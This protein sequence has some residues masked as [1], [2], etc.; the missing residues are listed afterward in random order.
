MPSI[1]T[2]IRTLLRLEVRG[3]EQKH[4][5]GH[6]YECEPLERRRPLYIG[7]GLMCLGEL[8]QPPERKHPED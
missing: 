5:N 4:V 2:F 7:R 3:G 6:Y 8:P 1:V